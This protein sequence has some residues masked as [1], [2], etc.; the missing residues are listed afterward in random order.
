MRNVRES[1]TQGI[2]L[3]KTVTCFSF[4]FDVN[5]TDLNSY[6]LLLLFPLSSATISLSTLLFLLFCSHLLTHFSLRRNVTADGGI[7][8]LL[9]FHVFT[10]FPL[11]FIS[12]VWCIPGFYTRPYVHTCFS[13]TT[14][15]LISTSDREERSFRGEPLWTLR[16][17]VQ[18]QLTWKRPVR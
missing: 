2:T 15:Y 11:V 17:L 1:F 14:S 9:L 8:S 3:V 10:S 18:F 13:M 16:C 7:H 5:S 6:Y 4:F 12:L